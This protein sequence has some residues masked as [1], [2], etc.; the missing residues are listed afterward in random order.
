MMI[1]R[2]K[3]KLRIIAILGAVLRSRFRTDSLERFE[4]KFANLASSKHAIAMPYGRTGLYALLKV[5]ID[6][7]EGEV[8]CPAYTCVVVPHAI[9]TSGFSPVFVDSSKSAYNM[10]LDLVENAITKNTVAVVLTSIFGKPLNLDKV[11]RMRERHKDIIFIQDCA[12][13]FFCSWEG[14]LVHK[15]GDAAIYGLNISKIMTS[16]FGGVVTTDSDKIAHKLR[17]YQISDL[18]ERNLKKDIYSFAYAC[19]I[20][21]SFNRWVYKIVN[22][23]ENADLLNKFVKYFDESKID[24]PDDYLVQMSPFQAEIGLSQCIEYENIVEHRR[25][26]AAIYKSRLSKNNILRILEENRGATYSHFPINTHLADEII[27]QCAKEGYQLG[28]LIDYHIPSM[29]AYREYKYYSIGVSEKYPGNMIN[30]PVHSSTTVKDAIKLCDIIE[31]I[32]T[33]G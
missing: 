32:I 22:I 29:N 33:E 24:M 10:D 1:P 28:E 12:H 2:L 6:K 8:I 21:L 20:Y 25:K 26:V 3:P 14:K 16:I 27:K 23:L 4:R 5:L 30:L 7:E 19:A 17:A 18:D 13:S 11:N 15:T 31:K 9:V